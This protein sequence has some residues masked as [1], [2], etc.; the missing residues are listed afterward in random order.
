[1]D[2]D[3]LENANTLNSKTQTLP[4]FDGGGNG[5]IHGKGM[6]MSRQ[7]SRRFGRT[8]GTRTRS[9]AAYSITATLSVVPDPLGPYAIDLQKKMRVSRPLRSEAR[10]QSDVIGKRGKQ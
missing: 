7:I 4:R 1:M 5:K 2:I 6:D 3:G 9:A 8:T 10:V